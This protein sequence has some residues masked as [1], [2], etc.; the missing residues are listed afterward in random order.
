MSATDSKAK[1]SK[2]RNFLKMGGAVGLTGAVGGTGV[3]TSLFPRVGRTQSKHHH[4]TPVQTNTAAQQGLAKFVD[5]LPRAQT[6]QPVA[7]QNGVPF[8]DVKMRPTK[9]KLHRDLPPTPL[10]AYNG[11][12]PAPTFEARRGQP[13]NVKWENAL[14]GTHFLPIDQTIH[15]AEPPTPAVRTVVHL[16]GMKSMP[17]SDG[18]PEAWFTNGFAQTGPFFETKVYNYPNDQQATQLWYHDHALGIT[19]LNNYAGLGGGQYL[20][21]DSHEDSLGLPSGDFEVPLAIADRFLNPDGSLL[22]PV[23]D[24]GGDPDP[25]VPPVWIPEFFGDTVLVNGKVWPFLEVEPRK[26]RFRILNASNSRFYHMTLQ[27]AWASGAPVGN[28]GPAF[29]QIGT[30]GGLLPAPVTLTDMLMAPAERR[31]VVIDFTGQQG[32]NFLLTN[33]APA[34]FPDGDDV[35]PAEI[36]LFKVNQRLS[37]RDTSRVPAVLNSVPLIKPSSAVK[38]RDLVLSELDSADPFANPIIAMIND[39]HWDD[40]VTETPKQGTV[41]V[42]RI[43]N[44][45]GD[46]HPIHVHL[47]QFQIIDRRPFDTDKFPT[48]LVYTGPAVTPGPEERPAWKDTVISYPGTVTRIIAKFDLPAGANPKPGDK[49]LYVYHCHILEHEENEMMRPYTVL[50]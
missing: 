24:N 35:V 30:D 43:I 39:A 17:A 47:V 10:W 14:P 6:I 7:V 31:D 8:Y 42:W 11:Q 18:Y 34:P 36:M 16:H 25:R 41:E 46:G 50:G 33:D 12:F 49:F 21:R 44:T 4:R 5:A 38:V 13:I 15:G 23:E 45:T 48:N 19:R 22:Y 29:I 32:K 1:K 2:R 27:E 26:Y 28:P 3:L 37:S 9:Q 40:P 20:I